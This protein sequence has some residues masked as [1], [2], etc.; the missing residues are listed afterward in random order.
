MRKGQR[1][2]PARL[3]A[4]LALLERLR[5]NPSLRIGDHKKAN[6]SGIISH[7]TF[8]NAAHER[9]KLEQLN[10]N[11]GRRSSDI[12]E[13]GPLLLEIL[14]ADGFSNDS[15]DG[16]SRRLDLIQ[17]RIAEVIR[18]ILNADP[19]EI[20]IKGRSAESVIREVLKQA[21]E[22]GRSG[23]V[24][25]YLVGAKLMLRLAKDI[26][27]HQSN[28]GDRKSRTDAEAR[29]GDFEIENTTIEVALGLP[30]PKHLRQIAD[31]LEDSD[32]Q[33]WLLTRQDRAESWKHELGLLEIDMKRVV[34]SSVE[35]FVGQNMSEMGCFSTKGIALQFSALF[36]LYNS[37]WIANVGTPGIRIVIK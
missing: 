17:S 18:E 6:S 13:W 31:A 29:T 26:P 27:M 19:I 10:K 24:A 4:A 33:V 22:K 11:H 3:Q 14:E 20:R 25:Q 23:D 9:L 35:A 21:E 15:E 30:D 32:L 1:H 7:E 36:D 16:R 12:G 5:T 2:V 37:R 8:G 34:V 28:K